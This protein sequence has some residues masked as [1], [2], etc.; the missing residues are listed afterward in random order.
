MACLVGALAYPAFS[1]GT[2]QER[3]LTPAQTSQIDGDIQ[4]FLKRFDVTGA[5]IAV[6]DRGHV[7]YTQAYGLRSRDGQ[8]SVRTDTPFEIGSITKQFTAAAILQLQEAGKLSIDA[9]LAT[10]LPDAPH[11][12]EVTLRQLLSHTSGLQDYLSGPEPESEIDRLASHPIS[13]RDLTAR[14]QNL[15]LAFEP[16]SHWS[17]SNTGYLLLGRVIEVVSGES[18]RAYLQRHILSPLGM[19][20]TFTYADAVQPTGTALGYR[21]VEGRRERSPDLHPGWTGA[22]GF[23]VSTLSDLERW[24]RGLASGRIVSIADYDAMKNET[25]TTGGQKTGYGLG[26]FVSKVFDQP[27]TGH[28]GGT[29]GFTA[30]DEYFPQQQTRIIALTNSGDKTPEAGEAI[31]NIVFTRLHPALVAKA[32]EPAGHEPAGVNAMA[33][34]SFGELQAGTVY[35][36]FTAKLGGRLVEGPGKKLM[37]Q[38]AGYGNVS[39]AIFKGAEERDHQTWYRYVLIFSPGVRMDYCVR[40]DGDRVAGVSFG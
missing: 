20:H 9:P 2:E 11:A 12:K 16:G 17:Y 35:R 29:Q 25:V 23:L 31:T 7:V 1:H 5:A 40:I 39:R 6:I 19:S 32:D 8:L 24:D 36:S 28:T 21:H 13:Y 15:P 30:A 18:Y 33:R 38:F 22:A 34:S 37:A 14:I 3:H 4:A 27:R 10:Y 26:L